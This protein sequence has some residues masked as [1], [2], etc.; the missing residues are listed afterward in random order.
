M[1]ASRPAHPGCILLSEAGLPLNS[2]T[3]FCQGHEVNSSLG[4]ATD[5]TRRMLQTFWRAK[6]GYRKKEQLDFSCVSRITYN[7]TV[8]GSPRT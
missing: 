5:S 2:Q 6:K 7:V 8:Y 3:S 1:S 4:A